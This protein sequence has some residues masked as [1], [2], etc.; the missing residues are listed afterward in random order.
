MTDEEKFIMLNNKRR[1]EITKIANALKNDSI[2]P[3]SCDYKRSDGSIDQITKAT[4]RNG[5]DIFSVTKNDKNTMTFTSKD[6]VIDFLN[7]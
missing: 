2:V 7:K 5:L 4:D 6:Q 1:E 3:K